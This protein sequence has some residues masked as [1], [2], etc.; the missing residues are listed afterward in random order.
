MGKEDSKTYEKAKEL[1]LREELA[2]SQKEPEAPKK[3]IKAKKRN[4]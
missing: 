3:Q 1:M 4:W 2:S